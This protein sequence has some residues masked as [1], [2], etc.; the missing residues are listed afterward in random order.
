LLLFSDFQTLSQSAYP[1]AKSK[2]VLYLY[3]L[4]DAECNA[5]SCSDVRTSLTA[6]YALHLQKRLCSNKRKI[7]EVIK[8]IIGQKN[9]IPLGILSITYPAY[10]ITCV[11]ILER[12]G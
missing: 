1:V 11:N 6:L 9:L 3:D 7:K 8:V 2:S 10:Y 12:S 5:G 4:Y